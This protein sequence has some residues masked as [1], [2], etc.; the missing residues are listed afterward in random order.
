[1]A[2]VKGKL[3]EIVF[4]LRAPF[5]AGLKIQTIQSWSKL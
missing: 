3:I 5:S 2:S 1:M 4:E